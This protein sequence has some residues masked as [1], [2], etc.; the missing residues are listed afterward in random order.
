[1]SE[2][3][4]GEIRMFPYNFAPT[5]WAFCDGQLLPISQNTALFALL[6]TT[7]GGNGT[8]TFALPDFRG[9]G[10]IHPGQGP[11]L[12]QRTLGQAGGAE[13]V[14]L[15]VPQMPVHTHAANCNTGPANQESPGGNVWAKVFNHS[16]H[17]HTHTPGPNIYQSGS[18]N[19]QMS[20]AAI[21][22]TG[23]GQAHENMPPF[24]AVSFCIALEGVFPARS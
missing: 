21:A 24:L 7:Y 11:G 4:L 6:G 5:G 18:P 23:G 10:P 8:T 3:F 22:N 19:G 1:M 20:S 15:G 12:S 14:A 16:P 2:P 13:T 17:T 9:R